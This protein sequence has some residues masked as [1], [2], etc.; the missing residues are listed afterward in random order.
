LIIIIVLIKNTT[1]LTVKT[2]RAQ[3]NAKPKTVQKYLVD[4][5]PVTGK[6]FTYSL[7]G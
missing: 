6:F 5:P 7:S 1:F 2:N 4:L 3:H